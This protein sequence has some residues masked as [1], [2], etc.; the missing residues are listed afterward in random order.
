MPLLSAVGI[1]GLQ[2]GEDVNAVNVNRIKQLFLETLGPCPSPEC[3]K[4]PSRACRKSI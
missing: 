4:A 2:A 3:L 1:S